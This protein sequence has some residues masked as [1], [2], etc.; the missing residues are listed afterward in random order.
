MENNTHMMK[1]EEKFYHR[2]VRELKTRLVTRLGKQHELKIVGAINK[3]TMQQISSMNI[4]QLQQMIEKSFEHW[5]NDVSNEVPGSGD[6]RL[7]L[8][9]GSP[10]GANSAQFKFNSMSA[11][12]REVHKVPLSLAH[13][14]DLMPP[15]ASPR[16]NAQNNGFFGS[17]M[18]K[19]SKLAG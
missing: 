9:I 10:D 19:R 2:Q 12:G 4:N 8:K 7:K 17:T 14:E 11:A 3:L 6:D 1:P 15:K 5:I 13:N 18:D 16:S